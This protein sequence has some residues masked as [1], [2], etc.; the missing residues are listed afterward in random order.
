MYLTTR[1]SGCPVTVE[2][3]NFENT[4]KS[5]TSEEERRGKVRSQ[6]F[7]GFFAKQANG[8]VSRIK[9]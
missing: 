4:A 9:P 6:D 1:F 8:N 3:R 2:G 7:P 5:S